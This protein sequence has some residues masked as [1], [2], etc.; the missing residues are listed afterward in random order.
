MY[1]ILIPRN[2]LWDIRTSRGVDYLHK[3]RIRQNV[4]A[5]LRGNH[6]AFERPIHSYRGSRTDYLTTPFRSF[7]S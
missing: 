2:Q 4:I 6:I 1:V 3:L 7:N 5:E